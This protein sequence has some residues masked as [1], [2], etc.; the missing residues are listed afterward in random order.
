MAELN[1]FLWMS[2][3]PLCVCVCACACV[4]VCVCLYHTFLI[5]LSV[6]G[7]LDCFQ[8]LA[9]VNRS[10]VNNGVHVSFQ[11][12]VFIFSGYIHRSGVAGSYGSSIFSYLRN[13]H[14]V[15]HSGCMNLHSHQLSMRVSFFPHPLQHLI[16]SRLFDD[17]HSDRCEVIPH[18]VC[19]FFKTFL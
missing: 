18:C 19:V 12:T 2:N 6:D 13:F 4:C 10:P 3:I 1:S 14:S 5:Q 15:F 16:F 9:I 7:Q 17:S 11:I 8:I